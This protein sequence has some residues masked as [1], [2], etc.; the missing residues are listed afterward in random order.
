V[1]SWTG[2]DVS[3]ALLGTIVV[4]GDVVVNEQPREFVPARPDYL[5]DLRSPDVP[6]P[7][8]GQRGNVRLTANGPSMTPFQINGVS[9]RHGDFDDTFDIGQVRALA[10]ICLTHKTPW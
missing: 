10:W 3:T 1:R 8:A 5:A 4:S 7:P 9:Y 6:R 2:R